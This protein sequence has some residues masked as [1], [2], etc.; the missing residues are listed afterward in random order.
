MK[1][2][3][4]SVPR[5]FAVAG[6]CSPSKNKSSILYSHRKSSQCCLSLKFRFDKE[7]Q[8]VEH[9]NFDCVIAT[10][11]PVILICLSSLLGL[12]RDCFSGLLTTW[13]F[14]VDCSINSSSM[15][16]K[17]SSGAGYQS[18]GRSWVYLIT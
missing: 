14:L 5:K 7:Q 13:G 18:R 4:S 12:T 6:F 17:T 2:R 10:A 9:Y 11:Q 15:D 3:S 8:Q 16:F 1:T